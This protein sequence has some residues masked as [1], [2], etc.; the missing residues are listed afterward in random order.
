[1]KKTVDKNHANHHRHE[2]RRHLNYNIFIIPILIIVIAFFL[3]HFFFNLPECKNWDC[4]NS[5]LKECDKVLFVG[6]TDMIF[7]YKILGQENGNCMVNVKLLQGE[8]NNQDSIKLEGKEMVC[9]LPLALVT[10]PESNLKNC[11]GLLKEDIQEVFIS[12]L[13]TYIVKNLGKIN[14]EA[15]DIPSEM[16]EAAQANQSE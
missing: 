14:L 6:G 11:H 12:K 3:W 10:F 15:I 7:E 16:V 9:E 2:K 13:H 4:F 8:L 5:K 1:M